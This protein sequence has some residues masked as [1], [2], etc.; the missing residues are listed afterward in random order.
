MVGAVFGEYDPSK[1]CIAF[2]TVKP[3][4]EIEGNYI[5]G[6]RVEYD[7]REIDSREFDFNNKDDIKRINVWRRQILG[8]NFPKMRKTRE[9]WLE[10]EKEY[11]VYLVTKQLKVSHHVK[12][13]RLANQ[14]NAHFHGSTQRT[15]EKLLL[16][17]RQK[18]GVIT[19][20]RPAPWRTSAAIQGQASKWQDLKEI[21]REAV[22]KAAEK[23]AKDKEKVSND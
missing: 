2:N 18:L 8:R 10:S 1:F 5:P 19:E 7:I 15:G 22:A 4:P 12:W 17:G 9:F 14:F 20:D 3:D 11:V 16:R 21:L 23:A 6:K 13:R